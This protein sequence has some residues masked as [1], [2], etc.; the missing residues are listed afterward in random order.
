MAQTKLI[1]HKSH[2]GTNTTFIP[3]E[4]DGNFGIVEFTIEYERDSSS[5]Y[6]LVSQTKGNEIMFVLFKTK[7]KSLEKTMCMKDDEVIE[8]V[9]MSNGRLYE[10]I[11][12]LLIDQL[13]MY[14]IKE[15]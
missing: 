3:N 13:K 11:Q 9:T 12:A 5:I 6:K 8:K 1:N 14:R 7:N 15:K 10:K 4:L 2:S